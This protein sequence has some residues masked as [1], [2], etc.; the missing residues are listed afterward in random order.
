MTAKKRRTRM[1]AAPPL[2]RRAAAAAGAGRPAPISA[3]ERIFMAGSPVKARAARPRVV[4][5]R[6]GIENLR[7]NSG[8][9]FAKPDNAS[10][11]SPGETTEQESLD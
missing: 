2:P 6:K 10:F 4:A 3:S 7:G 5:I 1:A 11:R 9:D 8:L